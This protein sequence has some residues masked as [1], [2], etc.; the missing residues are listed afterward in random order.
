MKRLSPIP[1]PPALRWREFRIRALPG[2]VFVL[3]L[4]GVIW[5]WNT[6]LAAPTL[7]GE[8]EVRRAHVAS[9]TPGTLAKLNVDR[10]SPV[11][12]GDPVAEVLVSNPRYLESTLGVIKAEA[13]ILR[14]QLDPVATTERTQLDFERL[15]LE[16]L[17]QKVL[18]ASGQI[19][20]RY[21][22]AEFERLSAL[23]RGSTVIASQTEW[24]IAQRD[25]DSLR[26]EVQARQRLI[27]ELEAD[28]A[29]LRVSRP[30]AEPPALPEGWRLALDLQEQRLKQALAEFGPVTLTAPIDG[31]VSTVYRFSGD[32]VA[33]GEPIVT[34]TATRSERILAYLIPPWQEEPEAGAP[35]EVRARSGSRALGQARI[36]EVGRY[37]EP[38]TATV[39]YQLGL[40]ASGL[41][42]AA[43]LGLPLNANN[44]PITGL[45]LAISLPA[46]LNLRP[47]EA[48]DL[49]LLPRT[50]RAEALPPSAPN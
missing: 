27:Q 13:E 31:I 32:N 50:A 18:L 46:G 36:L 40:R 15:R 14:L 5:I 49:R 3:A 16:L 43:Q 8:V 39:A 34:I 21:A 22:E 1:T 29:R 20:L 19:Q 28:L 7:V 4:V 25:R 24:E 44:Q 6:Q 38:V 41:A 48:V 9:L 23:R 30:P 2:V 37:L 10:F 11:R 12:A 47:G 33:A 26:A 17:N 42:Q 45:P 35:V